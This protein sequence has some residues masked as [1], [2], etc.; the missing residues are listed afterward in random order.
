MNSNLLR[1]IT[2]VII[3]MAVG[4][5]ILFGK[6]P[7]GK[8]PLPEATATTSPIEAD[9]AYA[10]EIATTTSG[11]HTYTNARYGFQFTY[12]SGWYVGDNILGMPYGGTLQLF[13]YPPYAESRQSKS[14]ATGE[15]KIEGAIVQ[16]DMPAAY[17]SLE[18]PASIETAQFKIGGEFAL[19]ADVKFLVGETKY[20]VYLLQLQK[21]PG[22]ALRVIIYGD[23]ANF[24]ALD[25]LVKSIAWK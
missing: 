4:I 3:L 10:G 16:A 20:R 6:G 22:K 9:A 18:Y 25:D 1:I 23:Q 21:I 13:N 24:Y 19:R 14:F 5:L 8:A 2:P 15:N 7:T 11:E 17:T 12:P